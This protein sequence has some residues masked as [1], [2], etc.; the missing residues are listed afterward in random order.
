LM[1]GSLPADHTP[2]LS[3]LARCKKALLACEVLQ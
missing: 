3:K 2:G 1:G